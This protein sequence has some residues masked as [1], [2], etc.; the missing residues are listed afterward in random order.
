MTGLTYQQIADEMGYKSAGTVCTIIKQAQT[1]HVASAVEDHRS[2]ELER[3]DAMQEALWPRAMGGS[4]SASQTILRIIQA[5]GRLLG[6]Y[7]GGMK[8]SS[9]DCWDCCQGQPTLVVRE[10]D[11]RHRGCAKHGKF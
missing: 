10:D 4:V 6:L 11:C 3:L 7:D 2:L 9:R 8:R 5:R 1:Q